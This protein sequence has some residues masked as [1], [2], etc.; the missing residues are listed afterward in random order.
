MSASRAATPQVCGSGALSKDVEMPAGGKGAKR[1]WP[2]WG[3]GGAKKA[4][5]RPTLP[6]GSASSL[7]PFGEARDLLAKAKARVA[8][9]G[10]RDEAGDVRSLQ[11]KE[12]RARAEEA[13]SVYV[14]RMQQR[15]PLA[16]FREPDTVL[17]WK[18]AIR[19]PLAVISETCAAQQATAAETADRLVNAETVPVL[20]EEALQRQLRGGD[21]C[22]ELPRE[23]LA[24]TALRF[25]LEGVPKETCEWE[26]LEKRFE[27]MR[28]EAFSQL[29]HVR[30][31]DTLYTCTASRGIMDRRLY[32]HLTGRGLFYVVP[33]WQAGA[34]FTEEQA[35]V[36][37]AV[38]RHL[39]ECGWSVLAGPGGAGKTHMLR[40]VLQC[41]DGLLVQ[42]EGDGPDCPACGEERLGT[43]CRSCGRLREHAGP[44]RLRACF[45]GPTNRAVAVLLATTGHEGDVDLVFGTIHSVTRRRDLPQQ[46]LLVID[47]SSMLGADHGDLLLRCGALRRAAWLVVGDHLQLPPV[48]AGELLRPLLA[49]SGLPTLTANLRAKSAELRT[50][51]AG[52]RAGS[53]ALALACERH[54]ASVP[55][56][57]LGI[58][59]SGCDL[60]LCVRNE[61][62]IRYNAF[63]IQR[64]PLANDRLASLDDY[65]KLPTDWNMGKMAPRS[66]VPFV[67]MPVRMQTNDYRPHACRGALGRIESVYQ[68][69]RVWHLRASFGKEVVQIQASFFCIPEVLRPA[70][71]TTLHDAQGAQRKRVGI[72]L[73]PSLHC[74]L[75]TLETLYTA[76]SRAQEELIFFSCGDQLADML[77]ALAAPAPLRLAPLAILLRTDPPRSA[78]EQR[79]SETLASASPPP[80]DLSAPTQA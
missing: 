32:R 80:A 60:V 4:P 34:E 28:E 15:S 69:A 5:S 52:I 63:E 13:L 18:D 71:A 12:A 26:L 1:K 20:L 14:T 75:L 40:H 77:P 7:P 16:W 25:L 39:S 67:G 35:R 59:A 36:F 43:Q 31:G 58:S 2:P 74:P 51:I 68:D 17:A 23:R 11:A 65:R 9:V 62:R 70:F 29:H 50:M 41:A 6:G 24:K 42:G 49:R 38:R 22:G 10:E 57:Q 45:L 76:A 66:F 54:F 64:R 47:E 73:P 33:P 78:D 21:T 55:E 37:E 8:W 44:R 72:V 53:P 79:A 3:G 30:E 27:A 19:D 56:L 61:E 46:D 48:G